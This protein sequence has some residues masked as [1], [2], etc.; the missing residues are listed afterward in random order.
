MGRAGF[1]Q[2]SLNTHPKSFEV[3]SGQWLVV[4]VGLFGSGPKVSRHAEKLPVNPTEI[5]EGREPEKNSVIPTE[6]ERSERSGG[7]CFPK[8]VSPDVFLTTNH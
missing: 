1:R 7:T 6:A 3:A 5:S 4:S 8:P 2:R